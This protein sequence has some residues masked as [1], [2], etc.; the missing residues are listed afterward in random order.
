MYFA[1]ASQIGTQKLSAWPQSNLLNTILLSQ[2]G[3]GGG[4]AMQQ[5][6]ILGNKGTALSSLLF[7]ALL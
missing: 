5:K 4:R 2:R 3:K 1:L 7:L 6:S